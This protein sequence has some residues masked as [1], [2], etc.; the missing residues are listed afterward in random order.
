M[1]LWTDFLALGLVALVL[2]MFRV[3]GPPQGGLPRQ[4]A[5]LVLALEV[6]VVLL[7]VVMVLMVRVQ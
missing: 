3:V 4:V 2:V 7:L 6:M 5:R 1:V